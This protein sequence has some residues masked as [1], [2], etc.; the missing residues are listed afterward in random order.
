MPATVEHVAAKPATVMRARVRATDLGA[1]GEPMLW[2][3]GGT[4]ALGIAMI[5]GFLLLVL[6]NG[7]TT[8]YPKPIALVTLKNGAVL[9]GEP[10]RTEQYRLGAE[11]LAALTD[12]DR[13]NVAANDGFAARTLYRVGNY[14]IYNGDF[15]WVS[16]FEVAKT[17]YPSRYF[18][19]ERL[20]WGPLIGKIKS[21]DLAGE[22]LVGERIDMA[23]LTA[24]HSTARARWERVREIDHNG[25]VVA[26]PDP[27]RPR[28][29][30]GAHRRG[31][32]SALGECTTAPLDVALGHAQQE[33][34]RG[35]DVEPGL[36]RHVA[37]AR[38]R[39]EV[40]RHS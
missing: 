32:E 7:L 14:D 33:P 15:R 11:Q 3:F 30:E 27:K 10:A 17:E 29:V 5:V 16:E 25:L 36:D 13:R 18:F 37:R 24:A 35:E 38:D 6:W 28:V 1:R 31:L 8:F 39:R 12:A 23:R 9:A 4:L 26:E 34:E 19:V 2:L 22:T 40:D 20:E 21:V